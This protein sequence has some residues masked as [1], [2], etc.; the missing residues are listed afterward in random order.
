MS[1]ATAARSLLDRLSTDDRDEFDPE[2]LAVLSSDEGRVVLAVDEHG[3]PLE[4]V[5]FERAN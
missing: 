1:I 5:R 2:Q 3:I 4:R